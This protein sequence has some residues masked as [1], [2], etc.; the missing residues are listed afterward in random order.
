M[1]GGSRRHFLQLLSHWTHSQI[2]LPGSSFTGSAAWRELLLLRFEPLLRCL[3]PP[4]P[5]PFEDPFALEEE[6]LSSSSALASSSGCSQ[7]LWRSSHLFMR[8]YH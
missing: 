8:Q 2:S 3:L 5:P 6:L 7:R 1:R 4:P